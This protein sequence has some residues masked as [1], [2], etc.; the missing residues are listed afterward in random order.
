M[1][2][3]V[4]LCVII[5]LLAVLLRIPAEVRFSYDQGD[6]ALWV[7][8]G[9]VKAPLYPPKE[10]G[11]E[12]KVPAKKQQ[13]KSVSQKPGKKRKPKAKINK[14][15]ILYSLEKLPPILGR[16][17]RRIGRRI[18]ICPLKIHLLIASPDPADTAELYGKIQAAL[19]AGL[20]ALH[21]LVN[22]REQ[23]IRL[24]QDFT[25]DRLDCIASVG[26]SVRP[27]DVLSIALRAGGSLL[28]WLLGYRKLASPPP[29]PEKQG[30]GE[31]KE[32]T[33]A[34]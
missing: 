33:E 9:P 20:P 29:V 19:A 8:Y 22:I 7:R 15:Q 26:V 32:N 25:E 2:G 13:K 31:Q 27:W 28:N 14:A 6:M 3:I 16:A 4:I 21:R 11:E 18:R 17:L 34:A 5:L 12:E 1:A 10:S 30:D 23:D 24:F